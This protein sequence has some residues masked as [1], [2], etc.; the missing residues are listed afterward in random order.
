[1]SNNKRKSILLA[2]SLVIGFGSF[3]TMA[4]ASTDRDTKTV[5]RSNPSESFIK[6][7]EFLEKKREERAREIIESVPESSPL[8]LESKEDIVEYYVDTYI[9][10]K[11]CSLLDLP[12]DSNINYVPPKPKKKVKKVS[13]KEQVTSYKPTPSKLNSSNTPAESNQKKPS[14]K[15]TSHNGR[16]ISMTKEEREWLEKLIEAEATAES[17]EGKLSIAT[18]IANRIESSAFPNTVMGVIKANNGKFH[19]F[20]PWDDGRIYKMHPSN[21]TKKAVTE[22]FDNGVRNLPKE[23]AYFAVKSIAFDN[24]MGKTRKHITT[25][26]NHAFFSEYPK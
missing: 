10:K 15:T 23:T 3:S 13:K 14:Q 9:P 8:T 25:I 4:Y 5:I 22:V 6:I 11:G 19:Q 1:M 20:S 21:N 7:S 12:V 18:V 16:S 24:W 17:Y 26:G 2:L